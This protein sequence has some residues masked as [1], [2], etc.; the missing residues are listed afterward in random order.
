[1]AHHPACLPLVCS[2]CSFLFSGLDDWLLYELHCFCVCPLLHA[3]CMPFPSLLS[4]SSHP[5]TRP[6]LEKQL[7]CPSCRLSQNPAGAISHS[8]PLN[9]LTHFA[10]WYAS[11]NPKCLEPMTS[12]HMLSSMAAVRYLLQLCTDFVGST[13]PLYYQA[14]PLCLLSRSSMH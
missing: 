10:V 13:V 11:R 14:V 12:K 3:I 4:L 2:A 5:G 1:M 7:R 6:W 9:K 8:V